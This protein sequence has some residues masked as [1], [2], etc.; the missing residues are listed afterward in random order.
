M[1]DDNIDNEENHQ[2]QETEQEQI[3]AAATTTAAAKQRRLLKLIS[4]LEK[5]DKFSLRTRDKTDELVENFLENLEDDIHEMLCDNDIMGEDGEEYGGLDSDRDTEAEVETAIRFFPEVL[6][7]RE[8]Q[9][10]GN[11]YPIQ[12]LALARDDE[13]GDL[14]CNVKAVSFIPIVARLA[15]EFG[16]FEEDKRGG[17][18]CEY[19][20]NED[21]GDN[22][23]YHLMIMGHEYIDT[24]YLQV[25]IQLRKLGL[26]KKEDIQRYDLLH[27]LCNGK[28]YSAEKRYHY[29]AENR[30]KFLVEWDPS[31]LTQTYH[32]GQLPM[33]HAIFSIQGFRLVFAAGIHYYPKK[34]GISLLF[35]KDDHDKTSFQ[36]ACRDFGY[37]TVV[38]VI[39]ET[40]VDH[41]HFNDDLDDDA[42]GPY[43]IVNALITAAVDEDIHLDC[44]YF[45]L[46]RQPD[47]LQKLLSSASIITMAATAA[48][49]MVVFNS[50]NNDI[51]PKKRKRKEQAEGL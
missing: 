29:F 4:V 45:L 3:A 39:E 24:K 25:L 13:D 5:K 33:H 38:K 44:V 9:F 15:I 49:D 22:V 11:I 47:I 42:D 20:Y 8:D 28:S 41:H 19:D 50:N 12:L 2:V 1:D 31:A 14:Q 37:Q 27:N 26:L 17:L 30:F 10:D 23:L 18:L 36:Y 6:S 16:L 51:S 34:K 7:R 48:A 32:D 35:R 21:K 46:R 40:V 43:N